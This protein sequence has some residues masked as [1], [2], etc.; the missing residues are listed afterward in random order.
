MNNKQRNKLTM[1]EAVAQALQ[2]NQATWKSIKAMD[3]AFT[4]LQ[5]L[6]KDI[7]ITDTQRSKTTKGATQSKNEQKDKMALLAATMASSAYAYAGEINDSRLKAM[8]NYSLS[9]ISLMDDNNAVSLC[10]AIYEEAEK[11]K[12]ELEDYDIKAADFKELKENIDVFNASIGG[13][14]NIKSNR[15]SATKTLTTLFDETDDLLRERMDKMLFRFKKDKPEFYQ[16]YNNVRVI[17][18]LGSRRKEETT[19]QK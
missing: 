9:T 1:Y 16:I 5:Q 13:N 10:R 6:L 7:R 19:V 2:E 8:F 11:I 15:V 18:D 17:K 14:T 4:T 12:K 3:K